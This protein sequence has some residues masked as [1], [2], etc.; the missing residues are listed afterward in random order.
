M[1]RRDRYVTFGPHFSRRTVLKGGIGAVA[2]TSAVRSGLSGASAQATPVPAAP[3]P[4]LTGET[5]RISTFAGNPF[6]EGPVKAHAPEFEQLTG[7]TIEI[8]TA[9][10]NDLFTRAQQVAQTGAGDFDVLLLANTWVADFVNL[11]YVIALDD[12]IARDSADANLAW[13][14]VP[15]GLKYKDSWGGQTYA[16]IV[17]NDNQS[18][19][20]RKDVLED[21][22]WQEQFMT[23]AGR[24]LTVPQTLTEF[25]EVAK[26]FTGKDWG[27]E[28]SGDKYGFVTCILRGAQLAWYCYPWVAPYS[29]VP[30][31][32]APAQGI[33]L[34]DPDMNPLVNTEG[35]VRGIT[36][37]V[38]TVQNA[39]RP[40]GD[41][42][43]GAV[44]SEITN[45]HALMSFDWGDTGPASVAA[46]SVVKDK[47]GFALTPGVTE[48]FD[49]QTSTWVTV[50]GEPHRAP[51]HAFNGWSYYIT[52]QARNVDAAWAWIK[53]HAS[54]PVSAID[55]ASPNSGF[56]P[57]RTSHSTN[58]Q[59]WVEAGWTESE[60]GLY[61]E[62]I[63]A[64]TNHPNAVFDPRVPG[65]DRYNQTLE[66]NLQRALLGEADPQTAMD[67]CADEFNNITDELGREDQVAAYRAH[68]GM[69]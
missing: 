1:T 24:E 2:A 57:W 41:T 36:E 47:L 4:D 68:L 37:M 3:L 45:G 62:N 11:E 20:Y 33:F 31:G 5:I 26:F 7:A 28:V 22:A 18:M 13:D 16:L 63:L 65:A 69:A 51:T 10:F 30:T 64:V 29:V 61:V 19:F 58:L 54:P 12:L 35:Y 27:P 42:D 25:T 56:Q 66:L 60:A 23:E 55:V 49:W 67:D 21:P 48:Y 15:D 9:P 34:F 6:I 38:D 50:E 39:M 40:G 32:S 17:D 44:I 14:D 59:P 8:V 46:E 43:R 52:S 53:Y